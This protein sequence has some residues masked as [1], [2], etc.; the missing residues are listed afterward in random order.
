MDPQSMSYSY[1][2]R[3]P[4]MISSS[5]GNG[6][7]FLGA[8]Y[9]NIMP[10]SFGGMY[11]PMDAERSGLRGSGI[12]IRMSVMM[13]PTGAPTGHFTENYSADN[14]NSLEEE[15]LSSNETRNDQEASTSPTVHFLPSSVSAVKNTIKT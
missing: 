4:R 15:S 8:N 14:R 9:C 3:D 13:L 12:G 11:L 6:G 5:N 2:I 7:M 1:R 10:G